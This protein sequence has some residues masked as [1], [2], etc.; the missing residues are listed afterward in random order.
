MKLFK[1]S[2]FLLKIFIMF[3]FICLSQ[4]E[5]LMAEEPSDKDSSS[6]LVANGAKIFGGGV[7]L[8]AIVYAVYQMLGEEKK[9]AAEY[10]SSLLDRE[11]AEAAQRVIE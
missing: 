3:S 9:R 1:K 6:Q 10:M 11:L 4:G 2:S 5:I 7:V 8:S